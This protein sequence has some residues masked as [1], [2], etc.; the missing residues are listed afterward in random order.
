MDFWAHFDYKNMA[1]KKTY[2]KTCAARTLLQI[3]HD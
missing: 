2:A 3:V 1:G